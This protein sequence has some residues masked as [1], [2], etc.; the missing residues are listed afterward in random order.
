[1]APHSSQTYSRAR[2]PGRCAIPSPSLGLINSSHKYSGDRSA[3]SLAL[4]QYPVRVRHMQ[5][6][7]L[8]PG[9][10][11][12]GSFH[13]IAQLRQEEVLRLTCDGRVWSRLTLLFSNSL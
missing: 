5:T 11:A 1:M 12:P 10:L 9:G 2:R 8:R 13:L 4:V 3:R 6:I 7:D